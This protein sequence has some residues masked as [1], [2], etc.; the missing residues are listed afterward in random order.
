M[1]N[2]LFESE[3]L[4]SK[5]MV[6]PFVIKFVQNWIWEQPDDY[7]QKVHAWFKSEGLVPTQP[8]K[9]YRGITVPE[10][11][12]SSKLE[13]WT[14]DPDIAKMFSQGYGESGEK[15]KT[16]DSG[17]VVQKTIDPENIVVD[18]S[19]FIQNC[20]GNLRYFIG[21]NTMEIDEHEFIVK[22]KIDEMKNLKNFDEISEAAI[23]EAAGKK[24]WI[25]VMPEAMRIRL[26]RMR[27]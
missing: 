26:C 19:K 11:Q 20:D 1:F 10:Y 5:S 13:S 22:N 24:L 15:P 12:K 8:I 4:Y 14:S 9:L 21:A 6:P 27:S 23:N 7:D 18:L 16:R 3:K 2:E 25:G 17:T